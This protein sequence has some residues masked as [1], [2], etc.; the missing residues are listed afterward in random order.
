MSDR[1]A[2]ARTSAAAGPSATLRFAQDDRFV[3]MGAEGDPFAAFRPQILWEQCTSES[4]KQRQG[5][6]QPQ[7][8][9][10][11]CASLRMTD[12]WEWCI[13]ES[14]AWLRVTDLSGWSRS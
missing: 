13:S 9:R 11:R 10:L 1:K 14:F 4:L 12:L 3:G 2:K 8:L 7:V 5:Q 6:V